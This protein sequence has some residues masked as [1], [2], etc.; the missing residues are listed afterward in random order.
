MGNCVPG[1]PLNM[2]GALVT[3]IRESVL[4][5]SLFTGV[6]GCSDLLEVT[7]A[8]RWRLGGS[9]WTRAFCTPLVCTQAPRGVLFGRMGGSGPLG[10]PVGESSSLTEA[11]TQVRERVGSL[12]AQLLPSVRSPQ[13]AGTFQIFPS[14]ATSLSL[15]AECWVQRPCCLCPLRV[16]VTSM[17]V[18]A[19]PASLEL[20]L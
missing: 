20:K 19:C 10:A 7:W 5:L 2:A 6:R 8:I 18:L 16:F 9:T 11:D 12:R 13:P 3:A 4:W 14:L 15:S 1:T 17:L